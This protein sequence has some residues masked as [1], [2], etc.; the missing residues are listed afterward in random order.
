MVWAI[1]GEEQIQQ[2]IQGKRKRVLLLV[3]MIKKKKEKGEHTC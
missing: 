3:N 2:H 1:L